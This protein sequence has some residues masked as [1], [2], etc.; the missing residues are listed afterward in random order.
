VYHPTTRV[1]TVLELLQSHHRITGARLAERL[2]VDTRTVR[3]YIT[4]LQDLGIPVESERGR[5]GAYR[6]M[7]GF[8]LPPLMFTDDEALAVTLG[9]LLARR[10]GLA[11]TTPAMEGALAKIERVLPP[12]LR[13]RV[14]AV[15]DA[16]V[17]NAVRPD[18]TTP[19]ALVL[20]FSAAA[21]QCQRVW[22]RYRSGLA[23]DTEREIDPYGLVYHAGRWYTPAYCHLRQDYRVF[24]LDRVLAAELREQTFV[25]PADFDS[26]NY[27]LH[28]I[29]TMPSTWTAVVLLE[30]SIERARALVP[31]DLGTL[32]ETPAG[33]VLRCWVEGLSW[34]A[35]FLVELGCPFI[36][37]EPPELRDALRELV[38][39]VANWTERVEADV[40]VA[41]AVESAHESDARA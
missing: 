18:V 5:Y 6:L 39:R 3:R 1:L 27:V 9:L 20:T 38:A 19:H 28:S 21:G 10:L 15:R 2:E 31:P 12:L 29:A 22:L 17:F 4:M 26:L 7:P 40:E 35:R 37:R 33:V 24:R 8:K 30:T 32:E 11:A 23:K 14:R 34:M 25:R 13:E 16:V 36:V 41:A